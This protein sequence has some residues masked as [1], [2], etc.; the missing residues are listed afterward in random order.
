MISLN[1]ARFVPNWHA[2]SCINCDRFNYT[3]PILNFISCT[4]SFPRAWLTLL[5][6]S[7]FKNWSWCI[8]GGLFTSTRRSF[9][10]KASGRVFFAM[11]SPT[12]LSH[13][14]QTFDSSSS[15]SL[16]QVFKTP[17]KISPMC[18]NSLFFL[19]FAII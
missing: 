14:L 8:H 1:S 17:S 9:P 10:L 6:I 13:R 19:L 3:G 18:T 11:T 16:R 5:I 2:G 12:A 4:N 15:Q 7:F